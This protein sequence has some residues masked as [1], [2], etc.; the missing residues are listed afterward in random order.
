MKAITVS[1]SNF[2]V[3]QT[4]FSIDKCFVCLALI[5]VMAAASS[6]VNAEEI[7]TWSDS[8]GRF[9]IEAKYISTEGDKVKLERADGKSM[10]I[11]ISKLSKDDQQ[12]L[13]DLKNNPFKASNSENPFME[14]EKGSPDNSR[15]QP[16]SPASQSGKFIEVNWDQSE[17]IDLEFAGDGWN[18]SVTGDQE[19]P[20]TP[21]NVELPAWSEFF[22]GMKAMAINPI[23]R[24]AVIGYVLDPPG[25][26]A[27]TR[28]VLC[29]L[30]SG[31]MLRE[32]NHP[33]DFIP[34][35]VHDDGERVLM[36]RNIFGFGKSDQ[37]QIWSLSGRTISIGQILTPYQD[38]WKSNNDVQWATFADGDTFITKSSGGVVA[39]WDFRTMQ[40][41]CDF[42]VDGRCRPALSTDRKTLAF[43]TGKK[44]GLFDLPSRSVI[45]LQDTPRQLQW[46]NLAFSP[47]GKL[48]GCSAF[49]S[50]LVWNT[51]TGELYRDFQPSGLNINTKLEFADE[52]FVLAGNRYLIELENMIKLW[53]YPGASAVESIGGVTFFAASPKGRTGSLMARLV[54]HEEALQ[55]LDAALNDP[56]LFIFRKGASAKLDLSGIA[57]NKRNEVEAS[58]KKKLSELDVSITNSAPVTIKCSV[59]G[60]KSDSITYTN[61]GTFDVQQYTTKVEFLYDGTTVWQSSGSN[62][63]HFVHVRSD[64]NLSD[65]LAKKSR[66]ADYSFFQNVNLPRFLQ[67][68]SG[69][70]GPA[71]HS[72]Q[73]LGQTQVVPTSRRRRGR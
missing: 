30:E 12:Y 65:I 72:Y 64:E 62:I 1:F 52:G 25:D 57:S 18:Y 58:L 73:T 34:L 8:T 47:S 56:S 71:A 53:D 42:K 33:G 69:D 67:K 11:Q 70:S 28:L 23:A 4:V 45:A 51:E 38:D 37:I 26:G 14:T 24:R 15:T 16:S 3:S 13:D 55:A 68:P 7:R 60:P 48:L 41:I 20:F 17:N 9:K 5:L 59:T 40:P 19:L 2:K 49:D 36:R 29:D 31:K 61:F 50:I 32:I 44:I 27:R 22:E 43:C 35:A 46:T 6:H 21:K 54:P 63:P 66:Q 39:L 10:E